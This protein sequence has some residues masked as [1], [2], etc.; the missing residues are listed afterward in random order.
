MVDNSLLPTAGS[1]ETF[2]NDDIGG[3]KYPR[4]KVNWGADGSTNDVS[5]ASGMALPVQLCETYSLIEV[6]LSLDTSPYAS[7]ELLAD[8]Q[9][10]TSA[11]KLTDGKAKL[12]SILL[13]DEDDQGAALDLYFLSANNTF[14]TENSAP[15]ISDASAR[16]I[17][18]RIPIATGDYYDLGGV[19]VADLS[20]LNRIIKAASGTT[21]IYVAA[22]NG[23]GTP[24]YTASGLKLRIGIEQG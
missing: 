2:A 8:T 1:D 15:S 13:I 12:Q 19:R 14:G 10:V 7:G 23:S 4:S 6:T 3:V 20:G 17:L 22:V 16:D 5:T 9:V 21:S 11:I 18:C 24:T